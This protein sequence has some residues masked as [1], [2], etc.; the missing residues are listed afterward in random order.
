MGRKSLAG[1]LDRHHLTELYPGVDEQALQE[2]I[3]ELE[4]FLEPQQMIVDYDQRMAFSYDATGERY[5]PDVVVFAKT[6]DEVEQVIRACAH[7]HIYVIPRGSSSNLSGGTTPILGG[8]VL[9]LT[10]QRDILDIDTVSREVRIKPGVINWDL[11]Q[12]LNSIGFFYPPDPASHKIATLGGNVAENSGGPHCVKYGVTTNHVVQLQVVLADGTKVWTPTARDYRTDLDFTG[13]LVGSEGTMAIFTEIVVGIWPQPETMKTMLGV[14]SSVEQALDT[15]SALIAQ[16]IVPA[17][18]ELL[19]KKSLQL[20]ESFVHAGYPVDAGAVLLIEVDGPLNDVT[21]KVARIQEI[22]QQQGAT[23]FRIAATDLEA[24]ALWRGRRS[25]Y[26]AAARLAPHLW[27]QDVTVP[28]PLL[29]AMM[30]DVLE[31]GHQYG[32]DIFCSAHAGDGNL[33]PIITYNPANPEELRRLKET[34]RAILQA[35]VARG[36]AITGEH[37]VGIDKL[38]NL[39][40]MYGPK[41]RQIMAHIKRAFDPKELLNPLKVVVAPKTVTADRAAVT[42]ARTRPSVWKPSSNEDLQDAIRTAIGKH[43]RLSVGGRFQ[44]WPVVG[45]APHTHIEMTALNQLVDFD[46]DNLTLEVGAGFAASELL[47]L[48]HQQ[49]L[50]VPLLP[51]TGEDTVGGLIASNARNWRNSFLFGW[52]DVVLG[53]EWIDGRGDVLRFGRKTMKN[54][55]G[56]DVTKLAIGSWGTLGAIS[57]VILRLRPYPKHRLFGYVSHSDAQALLRMSLDL[58]RHYDRPEGMVLTHWLDKDPCLWFSHQSSGIHATK[59][60]VETVCKRLGFH[61]TWREEELWA[62]WEGNRQNLIQVALNDGI[63]GEGGLK[64]SQLESLVNVLERDNN[65]VSWIV[66]PGSGAFEIYGTSSF[67]SD[68]VGLQRVVGSGQY[69]EQ[70][71]EAAWQTIRKRLEYVFDPYDIFSKIHE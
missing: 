54:V 17:T 52:R 23:D 37:G 25:H 62:E 47:A 19:D 18:L 60:L 51:Y 13:I 65:V 53:V 57:K 30:Q 33:H 28:R 21:E 58:S 34:D 14:F 48:L 20:V 11:Q 39:D 63:Y 15:V 9:S 29:A 40:L 32:F 56:Y 7:H 70:P 61:I 55:A 4:R 16:Q 46:P 26:G 44:R 2:L 1:Q 66:Y 24:D 71:V 3:H 41:E 38:E 69:W 31:I 27:I 64:P 50:D 68:I 8:L 10:A 67:R 5:V 43:V 42:E 49:E 22:V 12:V 6:A 36:G 59:S 35:C 45:G